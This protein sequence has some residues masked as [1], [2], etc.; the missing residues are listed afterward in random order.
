MIASVTT[1]GGYGHKSRIEYSCNRNSIDV[2]AIVDDAAANNGFLRAQSSH[3]ETK[4][5]SAAEISFL[6]GDL[7][8]VEM[9]LIRHIS[10]PP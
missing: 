8:V 3:Q 1:K 9:S 4:T 2:L 6:D 10:L 5:Q 7:D